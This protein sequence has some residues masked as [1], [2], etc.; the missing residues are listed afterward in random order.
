M[1]AGAYKNFNQDSWNYKSP[2]IPITPLSLHSFGVPLTVELV[3]RA[4]VVTGDTYS[5]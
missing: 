3:A 4:E 2:S 1:A 5:G